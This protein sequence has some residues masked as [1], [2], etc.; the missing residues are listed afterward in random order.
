MDNVTNRNKLKSQSNFDISRNL[1]D[2]DIN[3]TTLLDS[4]MRSLPNL[5]VDSEEVTELKLKY[6]QIVLELDGAHIEI[7]NLNI[8]ISRLK[9]ELENNKIQ[10]E[11]LKKVGIV[12]GGSAGNSSKHKSKKKRKKSL[13]ADSITKECEDKREKCTKKLNYEEEE[14]DVDYT[15]TSNNIT[16][17]ENNEQEN[18][19]NTQIANND[20][21]T[22]EKDTN[23]E[24]SAESNYN[25]ITNAEQNNDSYIHYDNNTADKQKHKVL[26]LADQQGR[27]IQA[28]L[29]KLLGTEYKVVSHFKPAARLGEVISNVNLCTQEFTKEDY[30][31]ILAGMNDSDPREASSLLYYYLSRSHHSNIIICEVPYNKNINEHKLNNEFKCICSLFTRCEFIDMGFSRYIPKRSLFVNY[32]TRRLLKEILRLDYGNKYQKYITTLQNSRFIQN[33]KQFNDAQTQ[34]DDL[35]GPNVNCNN[36]QI[37]GTNND[38]NLNGSQLFREENE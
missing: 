22:Q 2:S 7:E 11:T 29:Q 31:I 28:A 8:E 36:E 32:I 1:S 10:I 14:S 16:N 24:K 12:E 35:I 23:E 38:D 30:I 5:S 19:T 37:D 21:N 18:E 26:I 27:G 4:T 15:D 9:Q 20:I 25:N 34:T 6:E 17:T 13:I 3:N 33:D